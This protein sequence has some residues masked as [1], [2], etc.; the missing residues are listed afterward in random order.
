MEID[1]AKDG[2]SECIALSGEEGKVCADYIY[3][4]PP[5]IP[6]IVPGEVLDAQTI[7]VIQKCRA[8][9]LDVEGLPQTDR[10][11]VVISKRN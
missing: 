10:V 11:N 5:G 1:E 2:K 3:L 8:L 9:G 4:Y 7:H 6:V